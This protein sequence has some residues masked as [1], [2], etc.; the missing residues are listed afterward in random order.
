MS[1]KL[2]VENAY[3]GAAFEP[4]SAQHQR[5]QV[6]VESGV[7]GGDMIPNAYVDPTLKA[8]ENQFDKIA[9][10]TGDNVDV[11]VVGSVRFGMETRTLFGDL[12]IILRM[13]KPETLSRIKKWVSENDDVTNIRDIESRQ[14]G[15]SLDPDQLGDKFS[16]LFPIHDDSGNKL[17]IKELRSNFKA[18]KGQPHFTY[19]NNHDQR[20]KLEANLKN[21]GEEKDGFAMIQID[22]MRVFVDGMEFDGLIGKAQ[23][24]AQRLEEIDIDGA[25]NNPDLNGDGKIEGAAELRAWLKGFLEG[26]EVEEFQAHYD[27]LSKHDELQGNDD[28]RLLAAIH[29]LSSGHDFNG[30]VARRFD[31]VGYRYGFHPDSLQM[32]YFLANQLGMP[33]GDDNFSEDTLQ[34]LLNQ[35][36]VVGPAGYEQTGASRVSAGGQAGQNGQ[37]KPAIGMVSDKLTVDTM[38]NPAEFFR[39][40]KGKMKTDIKQ[41][42]IQ[43]TKNKRADEGNPDALYKNFGTRR[44]K[45]V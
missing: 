13:K 20:M 3:L 9:I 27:F 45:K 12:D 26:D 36:K 17:T 11:K 14:T 10:H 2:L 41:Y 24:L 6:I 4:L 1:L 18:L 30:D 16:F 15:H 8:I 34:Q 38:R 21:F 44:V 42:V 35:A 23:K 43:N 19:R 7:L 29:L 40:L 37:G 5:Q 32:I 31:N 28:Q 25:V 33:L 22:V 39:M